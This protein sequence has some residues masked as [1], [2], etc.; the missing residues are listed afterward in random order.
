MNSKKGMSQMWWIIAV[1]ILTLV[2]VILIL[3]FFRNSSGRLFGGIDER[4]DS[5]GDCDN[6]GFANFNDQC[7]CDFGD[8]GGC[9]ELQTE[10]KEIALPNGEVSANSEQALERMKER[11]LENCECK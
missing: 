9:P 11:K 1:A 4:I 3:L 7:V 2:I 5:L 6:D 8:N 10:Q